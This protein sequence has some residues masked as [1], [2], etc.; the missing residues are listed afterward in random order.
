MNR[1]GL[2]CLLDDQRSLTNV[3]ES[4]LDLQV[5]VVVIFFSYGDATLFSAVVCFILFTQPFCLEKKIKS[6]TYISEFGALVLY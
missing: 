5:F 4:S 6:I 2:N 3:H 1:D